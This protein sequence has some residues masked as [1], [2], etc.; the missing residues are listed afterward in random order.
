VERN[1]ATSSINHCPTCGSTNIQLKR[2]ATTT[3]VRT[4][5]SGS[6]ISVSGGKTKEKS[7]N[8]CLNCGHE[9]K[10]RDLYAI[11]KYIKEVTGF[12]L[13]LSLESHR[14]YLSRFT[15]KVFNPHVRCI[16]FFPLRSILIALL[17]VGLLNMY[18]LSHNLYYKS[19][20]GILNIFTFLVN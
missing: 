1:G 11:R 14:D 5:G 15:K 19:I 18:M 7:T 3:P 20:L 17:L 9:W 10:A 12:S 2:S 6:S 13:D 16:K 8:Y 4:H